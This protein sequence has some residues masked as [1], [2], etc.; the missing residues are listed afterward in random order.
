MSARQVRA[1][2]VVFALSAAAVGLSCGNDSG[3]DMTSPAA[4]ELANAVQ[5]VRDTIEAGDVDGAQGQLAALRTTV[6]ELTTTGAITDDRAVQV[7]EAIAALEQQL[8]AMVQTTTVPSASSTT[9][10]P[11]T[12][13]TSTTTTTEPSDEG[14][15]NRDKGKSDDGD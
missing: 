12:T 1:W 11:A 5:G 4:A 14:R 8:T 9:R 3:R 7:N 10:A 6:V 15:G 2:T 13:T